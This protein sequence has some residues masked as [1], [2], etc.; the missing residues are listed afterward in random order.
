[1]FHSSP[2]SK[3]YVKGPFNVKTELKIL[4]LLE[5]HFLMKQN[6]VIGIRCMQSTPLYLT[7]NAE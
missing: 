5:K 1:M 7:E 6:K 4:E 2:G 3:I